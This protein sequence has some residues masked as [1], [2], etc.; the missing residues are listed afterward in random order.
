MLRTCKVCGEAKPET[1]EYFRP[2]HDGNYLYRTCRK[3]QAA[4]WKGRQ[5]EY[6]LENPE[7][8]RQIKRAY[9]KRRYHNDPEYRERDL[10][11][12]KQWRLEHPEQRREIEKRRYQKLKS[13]PERY[14]NF[15][16]YS[17]EYQRNRRRKT[18]GNLETT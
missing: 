16:K 1:S 3:C 10:Q 7:K 14:S 5:K 9:Q 11:R 8:I 12:A 6:C 18:N 15:L 17:R 2:T 4:R 13:D